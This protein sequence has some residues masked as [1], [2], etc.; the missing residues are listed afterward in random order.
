MLFRPHVDEA[1]IPAI[2]GLSFVPDYIDDAEERRLRTEIDK[3]PWDTTWQRRR[4]LYG[5]SYGSMTSV[6]PMPDWGR[7]LADRMFAE[8]LTARP[9]DQMLI[10][11]Y[12]PGQGIALH[13]DYNTSDRT[14]ASLSL[15]S[16]CVM[17]FRHP[18]S[19]AKERL[20]LEPRSL[21]VLTDEARYAW[22][23]G[24]AGRKKD[25]WRGLVIPRER[26]LS[27]TFR[28]RKDPA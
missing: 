12:F 7:Q 5:A 8:G 17:D 2:P 13:H 16:P 23:H 20:L 10:N 22:Q 15:L 21:L 1:D 11:E 25:N 26:R 6:A 14:V 3:Q 18:A 24:I 27:V 19:G 4:Q 28:T 9:F